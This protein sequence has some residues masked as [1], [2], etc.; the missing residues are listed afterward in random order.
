MTPDRMMVLIVGLLVV[1][2]VLWFFW[3]R[4]TTGV[5]VSDVGSSHQEA[6]IVVKRGYTPDTIVVTHGKPVRLKSRHEETASCS[7]EFAFVDLNKSAALPTGKSVSFKLLFDGPSKH[8]FACPMGMF[9][10]ELVM[11]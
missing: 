2:F 7:E 1:T 11:A 5:R 6:A 9:R 3:L 10:G 8:E 4:G